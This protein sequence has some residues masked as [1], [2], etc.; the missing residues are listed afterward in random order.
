MPHLVRARALLGAALLLA[1]GCGVTGSSDVTA[2]ATG[3]R[4]PPATTA[5]ATTAPDG[6]TYNAADVMFTQMMVAHHGQ[7]IEIVRLASTRASSADVKTLAAAVEATQT[8]EVKTM[9]GWLRTWRKPA[10]AAANEHAAHGG[11][12]GTSNIEIRALKAKTG[13]TFDRAFLNM[14]IAHQDDAIQ[15]ARAETAA[16]ANPEATGLAKRIDES[17]TAQIAQM[18]TMLGQG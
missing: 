10:T 2:P 14:L 12:P 9:S 11:M 13:D 16:G 5:P 8:A 17:R 15:M 3:S 4:L 6:T 1:A 18:L 7:G